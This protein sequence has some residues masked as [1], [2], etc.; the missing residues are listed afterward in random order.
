M[1]TIL[2]LSTSLLFSLALSAQE[3]GAQQ[4]AT[5]KQENP[6]TNN[7][8]MQA[9]PT[10]NKIAVGDPGMP[11]ERKSAPKK[12]TGTKPNEGE[13]KSKEAVAPK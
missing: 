9:P 12:S 10:D 13:R 6:A 11:A 7:A 1:K 4:S 5:P 8:K 2:I 3:N